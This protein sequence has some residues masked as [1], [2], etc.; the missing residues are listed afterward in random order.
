[1]FIPFY[2]LQTF[3]FFTTNIFENCVVSQSLH[4]HLIDA[5][6][7]EMHELWKILSRKSRRE[8]I[9]IAVI[10]YFGLVT[11]EDTSIFTKREFRFVE[12]SHFEIMTNESTTIY[13][14]FFQ[15]RENERKRKMAILLIS[16]QSSHVDY[17]EKQSFDAYRP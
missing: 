16:H 1:M 17:P 5:W 2:H 7:M 8:F 13:N 15:E 3:F 6:T 4:H 10:S 9:V 11:Y 12:V 14:K